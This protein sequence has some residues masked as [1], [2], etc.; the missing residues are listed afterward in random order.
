MRRLDNI[1][2]RLL[3]VFIALAEAGGFAEAQVALNLSQSTLSTHLAEL[4]KRL[5]GQLC[6]RGRQQFRLTELGQATREAALKLFRDLDDFSQRIAAV[7]GG[8]SG[9][10]RIGTS[11][12]TMTDDR[13]GIQLAISRFLTPNTDV[14]VD[15]TL[16]TPSE[17]ERQVAD[18]ERDVVIGPLSQK[19][20]GVVY[21]D[22]V[23]EPHHLYCGEGHPLF[24]LPDSEITKRQVDE[25]RFSV[26]SYRHFDDLYLV[27]HPRASASVVHMEAQLIL[28]LSGR[29]IGFLPCHFAASH[30]A[31]G[32]LRA[33]KP[34][35]FNFT[36]THKIAYRRGDEN[37][38]LIA[39]FVDVLVC[40]RNGS[41]VL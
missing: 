32:R 22:F 6:H 16:D 14:F 4:E 40:L 11:D 9:R 33:V 15:L 25:A 38:A 29:F 10:L 37:R 31:Q 18:G 39:G 12:G 5:G 17:L 34:R 21:H 1:D 2:I 8:L 24:G 26:R 41:A 20:P 35:M 19:A 28:I 7:R 27:G 23:G 30:V 36:S 13:L 3:R